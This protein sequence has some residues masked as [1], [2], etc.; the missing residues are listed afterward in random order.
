MTDDKIARAT[1]IALP[2]E[3]RPRSLAPR[4]PSH[5]SLSRI[6]DLVAAQAPVVERH[7]WPASALFIGLGAA[8]TLALRSQGA[9]GAFAAITPLVAAAS[10]SFVYSDHDPSIEVA[11][12]TPTSP[13]AILLARLVLISGYDM[14]LA[15]VASL[16]LAATGGP[17]AG[18][19]A[20]I[21]MW[22][23]PMLLL[24]AAALAVAVRF[25]PVPAVAFSA[26][27]WIMYLTWARSI[28]AAI[29]TVVTLDATSATALCTAVA[30]AIG[31]VVT[32]R[33]PRELRTA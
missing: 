2:A 8:L 12:A 3:T 22:L 13:R 33:T 31:A 29:S 21:L 19:D 32:A 17:A 26:T 23:G 20:V 4:A 24:S 1:R 25:G 11:L 6:V 14:L 5:P 30:F 27:V 10:V 16:V 9:G 28:D 15:L 7:L 18:V